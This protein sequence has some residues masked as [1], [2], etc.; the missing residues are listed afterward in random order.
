[1]DA[2]GKAV[3]R[4]TSTKVGQATI[5]A[6]VNGTAING[7]PVTVNFVVNPTDTGKSKL[8]VTKD[9]AVADGVDYNE[10][11]ATIVDAF[12]NPIA[13]KDVVFDI[14]NVDGTTS[15]Q[16]ATTDAAGKA[17]VR[18]TSTSAGQATIAATVD[19]MGISGSPVVVN[20]VRPYNLS[21]TKV[22][23]QARV[24]AGESTTFTVTITNEGPTAIPSGKVISLTERPGNG[25][26]ITGYEVTSGNGTIN[27]TGNTPT[28]TTSANIPV[29][30]TIVVKVTAQI[31]VD[32]PATITNGIS[33]WGPDKPITEDPDDEDDTPEIP[34][35]RDAQLSITKVADQ[36]RVVAGTSTSFTVTITNN[37]PAEIASGKVITL[38]ERPGSGVSITGYEVTSG[39]GT[40]SGNATAATVTTNKVIP[41]NG[42]IIIKVTATV[43]TDAPATITNGI[44]VWGPDKP[45]TEEPDDED[46]T[47]EIPVD[48]VSNL[49]ITKVA[50]QARVQAGESTSFTVTITNNGPSDI[51]SGKVINIAELPSEGLSITGYE[52]TSGNGTASGNGNTATVIANTKVA[53]GG[54]IT[55]KIT[56]L[57][58][59]EAPAVISN[60]I[61]VWGPD[62]PVTQDPDD[63]DQT[64]EIPVDYQLPEAA[65]DEAETTSATPVTINV[66]AN[67]RATRWPLNVASVEIVNAPQNGKVA[68]NADGT[69]TYT[70]DKG[71]VGT[72]RFTYTV[73]DEKG[74]V[75]NAATVMVNVIPNPL[76]IPNAFTPNGDG[77]NDQFEIMGIEGY[78]RVEL[79]VFNRWG[80]EVYNNP[81]YNNNWDGQNL[82]EGTYYYLIKLIKEDKVETQK[83]WVLLKRQ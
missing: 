49:S 32:A 16:T 28:V 53:R 8:E 29:N 83:G 55:M 31:A 76:F 42:T 20:F 59:A 27:G 43:A 39:N 22:A 18:I 50:D 9:G 81:N 47:P 4:V 2:A 21:I 73:K 17:V 10:A 30:G 78:D 71:Y 46:D 36:A 70:S 7:S 35:D 58:N 33:V 64:P 80:N 66:L 60:G 1:T 15:Q 54:T 26:S 57:V 62:K 61:Q 38:T 68:V 19:G 3:V 82:N 75:S 12:E 6:T 65:D 13:N 51:L 56:G 74:N 24:K 34:V 25:V 23:D 14:T 72:D 63:E 11:T 69:V 79:Y 5:A 37:G 45:T 41:V 40:A 52:V 77:K 48:Y 44:S 67:D